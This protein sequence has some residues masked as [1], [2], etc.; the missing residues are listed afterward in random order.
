MPSKAGLPAQSAPSR[1][2][3]AT[4][5]SNRLNQGRKKPSLTLRL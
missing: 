2:T 1:S 3:S 5:R 4:C